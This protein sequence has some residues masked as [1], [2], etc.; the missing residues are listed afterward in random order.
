MSN[1]GTATL[2]ACTI[3]G[4]MAFAS[5][6]GF[7]NHD[8]IDNRGSATLTDTIVAGNTATGGA[9][10]DIGGNEAPS[11]TGSFNLIGTGGSGGVTGSV[12]GNIVLGSLAGLGLAPLGNY[13]GSTQTIALL[14]GSPALDAGTAVA[15]I[16]TD[17][18]GEPL[19]VSI[20]IGAFQSQGFVLAVAPG[21]TPQSAPTGEAFANP[22]TV[23][24]F[25]V[26]PV[27]PVVGGI[28][29]F[30]V[31]PDEDSGA[32][33]VLSA[34][35]AVIGADH[36]AQVTATAN[37]LVGTFIVTASTT[38]GLTLPRIILTNLP[39]DE[40]ALNFAGLIDRS[41]AFGA[42][43]VTLTGTLANGQQ[44]PPPGETVAITLGGV[45]HLA[46]I[47][48]GGAFSA[49]FDT[50]GLTVADSPLT[51]T[52][53]Y[54]SDG[55]FASAQ[56]TSLLMVTRATPTVSVAD[57]GGTFNG[58]AFPATV[59]IAGVDGTAGPSLEAITPSL[60]YYSGTFTDAAQ[61]AG[62]VPLVGAPSEAGSYTVI[63]RFPGSADYAATQ[64]A[65]V[66][67]TIG[68][69]A[70]AVALVTSNG[71]TVFGQP[72]TFVATV[73]ATG[74]PG[75]SVT[76]FDGNAPLGTVGLDGSGR[77]SLTISNLST[78]SHSITASYGGDSDHVGGTSGAATDSVAR[79]RH[80]GGPGHAAILPAEEGGIG[81]R[82][83][84]GRAIVPGR[85]HPERHGEVPVQEEGAGV[86]AA[87]RRCG[88]P[89][90]QGQR[91]AEEGDHDHLRRRSGLPAGPD[92]FASGGERLVRE[93]QVHHQHLEVR[94]RPERVQ[95]MIEGDEREHAEAARGGPSEVG[96]R[97][98]G[99]VPAL[100]GR[101]PRAGFVRDIGEQSVIAPQVV[102][103]FRRGRR[104][105]IQ[106]GDP[107]A[108]TRGGPGKMPRFYA[109]ETADVSQGDR[110]VGPIDGDAR[111]GRDEPLA[112][113]ARLLRGRK[114]RDRLTGVAKDLADL[115]V[116]PRQVVAE[117][118]DIRI[119]LSERFQQGLCPPVR[120]ERLGPSAGVAQ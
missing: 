20:D 33:A 53:R 3:S 13:G 118:G 110:Q 89:D 101:D 104:K 58:A 44:V 64:S 36:H 59:S 70:A 57:A 92:D 111:V 28:V 27:E 93:E 71:S 114:G 80:A 120:L 40:V 25:A 88:D 60:A 29:S 43:T 72:V 69:A 109:L 73:R 42:N 51:I 46:T 117:L 115:A 30:A 16:T 45:T 61:L 26:N 18:R 22:L 6:G 31:T 37:D 94:P 12:Q 4:N 54:T 8:F 7:D 107:P 91:P 65:P 2:T 19:D 105:S 62:L 39:N 79:A 5:G 102:I 48:A 56:T 74:I 47:G 76:F 32:G 50:A 66:N 17:Q 82:D 1:S 78:G 99:L 103:V 23:T 108:E 35:T 86:G 81:R 63:G 84:G 38:D 49:A 10:S 21:T 95:V 83:G 85:R 100:D 9:P 97:A 116:A 75:G 55:I 24:V 113:P 119:G 52:Y 67:F 68:R 87:P 77:A 11:I 34:L 96:H 98:I 14:P 41:I 112:Q 106:Q 90:R 15:G